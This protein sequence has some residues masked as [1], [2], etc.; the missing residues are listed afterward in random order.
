MRPKFTYNDIVR[1]STDS[2]QR[3]TK[4]AWI[5][6]IFETRP[7]GGYFDRFPEGVVY[8]IEFEDGSSIEVHELELQF[9]SE[10]RK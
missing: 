7:E 10:V 9:D 8:S 4:K 5:V 6:G 1:V 3:F 2:E